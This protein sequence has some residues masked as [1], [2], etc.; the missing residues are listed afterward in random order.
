MFGRFQW[1]SAQ[2]LRIGFIVLRVGALSGSM[3]GTGYFS[4][5]TDHINKPEKVETT[6]LKV[7]S[8]EAIITHVPRCA[9]ILI[10]V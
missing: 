5:V 1:R 8:T 9:L 7:S 6:L 10:C 4:G 3:Y 2:A